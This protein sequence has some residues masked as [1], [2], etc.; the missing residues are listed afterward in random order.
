MVAL[1]PRQA[2]GDADEREH[3]RDDQEHRYE[4]HG[5][6]PLFRTTTRRSARGGGLV[7]AE[8]RKVFRVAG[9]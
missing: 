7:E 3:H 4:R 6:V 9:T 5:E 1:P 8:L 2:D